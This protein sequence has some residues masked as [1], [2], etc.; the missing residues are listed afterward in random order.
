MSEAD[1]SA[2]GEVPRAG[3]WFPNGAT[4]RVVLI[5][6]S[7]F[8]SKDLPDIPAV[9]N[10][11]EDLKAAFLHPRHGL[12]ADTRPEHCTVLGLDEKEALDQR[13]IG[14][15]LGKARAAADDLL[16]VYYTGHG[17]VGDD[18]K[19]HLALEHTDPDQ[20]GF[21]A[22][23]LSVLQ[24]ELAG[25]RAAAR[26]LILD[27]CFSGRAVESMGANHPL[28]SAP[29]PT[30]G[31]Y[32][33][34]STSANSL[35][36]ARKG[37]RNS[38][39]TGALLQALAQPEPLSLGD[40]YQ[41]VRH[42]QRVLEVAEPQTGGVGDA[43]RVAL[44]RGPVP[45]GPSPVPQRWWRLPRRRLASRWLRGGV[46]VALT[47]A[48][49]FV[50]ATLD[51]GTAEPKSKPPPSATRPTRPPEARQPRP[52]ERPTEGKP[53]ATRKLT[54]VLNKT[55]RTPEGVLVGVNGLVG[56][57]Y[58]NGSKSAFGGGQGQIGGSSAARSDDGKGAN[59]SGLVS[60]FV[61]TSAR[62]CRAHGVAIG[63][64]TVVPGP[65][66]EW[67]KVL[68]VDVTPKVPGTDEMGATFEVTQGRGPAPEGDK[69]CA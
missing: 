62:G 63:E 44:V 60:F 46:L 27:C 52:A 21:T 61:D 20:T 48:G 55:K 14:G 15:A 26:V 43:H 47:S 56:D 28:V 16:L 2:T 67:T 59:T 38:I 68:V 42:T 5:G 6:A 23:P 33:L 36:M 57:V 7:T 49:A 4:S 50:Y 31:V 51:N 13:A 24:R 30:R 25:A 3:I 32:V 40:V 58:H 45:A 35:S 10:N 66:K 19:L 37:H 8:A 9:R 34:T 64:S 12:F 1:G 69:T 65:S 17:L 11:L 29:P 39:F 41:F 22:L 54:V 53:Y 18:S